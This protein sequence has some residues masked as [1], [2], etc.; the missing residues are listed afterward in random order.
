MTTFVITVPGTF[1]TG[2][3]DTSRAAL[4]EALAKRHTDVSRSEGLALLTLNDDGTFSVRLEVEAT[5]RYEAELEAAG[6]VSTALR[7]TGLS[8]QDV[9]LGTPVVTGIDSD[10]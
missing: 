6:L 5:D 10:L 2:I 8:E 1:V 3:S 7:E 4:E 9:P